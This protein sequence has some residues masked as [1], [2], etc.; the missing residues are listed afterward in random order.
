MLCV[1]NIFISLQKSDDFR[2]VLGNY[3]NEKTSSRTPYMYRKWFEFES[4][5]GQNI[6][7]PRCES[8]VLFMIVHRNSINTYLTPTVRGLFGLEQSY[9]QPVWSALTPS[10]DELPTNLDMYKVTV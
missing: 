3:G 7:V 8:P 1:I 4:S 5:G 10:E 9:E 2:Q 6:E